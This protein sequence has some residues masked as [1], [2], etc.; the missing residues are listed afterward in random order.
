M[1]IYL[2]RTNNGNAKEKCN[3]GKYSHITDNI[4][5]GN[6]KNIDGTMKI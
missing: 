4:E 2:D 6:Y 1:Y 3:E 5:V